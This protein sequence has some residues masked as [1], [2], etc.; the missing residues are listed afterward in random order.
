MSKRVRV[1]SAIPT[2]TI[3]RLMGNKRWKVIVRAIWR[4][5]K[6]TRINIDFCAGGPK[7]RI[8]GPTGK[9]L[10]SMAQVE[11]WAIKVMKKGKP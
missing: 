11:E 3:A 4:K 7:L 2:S 6:T 10:G 8:R 1:Y 9:C 5:Y